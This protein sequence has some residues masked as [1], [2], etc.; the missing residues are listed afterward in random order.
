MDPRRHKYLSQCDLR[1]K[2]P[3]PCYNSGWT[4]QSPKQS[5]HHFLKD[6]EGRERVSRN[7]SRYGHEREYNKTRVAGLLG[8]FIEGPKLRLQEKDRNLAAIRTSHDISSTIKMSP[9]IAKK[10]CKTHHIS[11]L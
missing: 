1:R 4:N 3:I 7:R 5:P 2:S 11:K 9:E 8:R 6:A 10:K